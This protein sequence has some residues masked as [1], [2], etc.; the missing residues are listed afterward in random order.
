MP[1]TTAG[2]FPNTSWTLIER[3]KSPDDRTAATALDELCVQNHYPL[4]CYY[5][6]KNK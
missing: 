2:R 4:Y 6:G 1:T 3:I 5:S